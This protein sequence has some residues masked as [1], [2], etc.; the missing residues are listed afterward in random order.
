[1][2]TDRPAPEPGPAEVAV[3]VTAAPITPLDVLCASG[4]SYFGRPA[5]PYVPGVQ[6]VG[7]LTR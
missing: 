5:T 3:S 4:T 7:V 1:M 2:V 6:G